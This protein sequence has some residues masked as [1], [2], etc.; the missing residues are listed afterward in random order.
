VLLSDAVR[1]VNAMLMLASASCRHTGTEGHPQ[2]LSATYS[3]A[4]CGVHL[5]EPTRS[6]TEI[7][8]SSS[9]AASA[10]WRVAGMSYLKYSNLCADLVRGALKQELRSKAKEREIVYFKEAV[11]KDGQPEKQSA[12]Q[13]LPHTPPP[14]P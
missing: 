7:N 14:P 6:P 12:Y 8:M 4:R 13:S 5:R 3:G 1:L 9:A 2:V 10:Y 11:W